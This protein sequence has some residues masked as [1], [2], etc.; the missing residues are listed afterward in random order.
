[1]RAIVIS[2]LTLAA[3]ALSA[4][5]PKPKDGRTD[6][7]Y[8]GRVA[9]AVDESLAPIIG[10]EVDVFEALRPEASVTPFGVTEVE[11]VRLLLADSVR[12]A[13]VSR[14]MSPAE[15]EGLHSRKFFPQEVKLAT[16]GLAL[17]TNK[18]NPDTLISV[19]DIRRVLTGRAE[20]WKDLYPWSD[21]GEL[22]LVF[23]NPNSGTVRFAIDSI[24]R[25]DSLR[26]NVRALRTNREVMDYVARTPNA[27]GIIGVN[28]MSDR[29]D[30]TGLSFYN[31]VNVMSVSAAH[32]ATPASG[33]KPFQAYLYSGQ[34]PLARP[35]YAW[36][37]DPRDGLSAGFGHFLT[38]DRGQ[39]VILKSGLVPAT[40]P[41]R[42]V[43]IAN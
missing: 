19:A 40:Q 1:M 7:F 24:C 43:Q 14:R 36:I 35:V 31:E 33:F 29:N 37:N 30:S 8:S 2:I 6:T 11:A 18:Q 16:D 13:I 3:L 26:G 22:T 15:L 27:I 42:L 32:P 4:C 17:I 23:D 5:H 21:L 9:I 10:E 39:R 34:Y 12:L 38:T 25:G 28:W 20:R 41:V